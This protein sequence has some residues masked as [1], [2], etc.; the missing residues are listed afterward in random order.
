MPSSQEACATVARGRARPWHARPARI[1]PVTRL[2]SHFVLYVADQARSRDFFVA[3]LQQAPQLDVPGMTEFAL[4][5]GG[6]LGLMPE[7]GIRALLGERLPDPAQARGTPRAELYLVVADPD[8]HHRR[9]LAAGAAELS[10]PALRRWG[11]RA[12]Y[13]LDP[14]GHVLAFAADD[15]SRSGADDDD[16]AESPATPSADGR[17][18]MGGSPSDSGRGQSS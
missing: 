4:A 14:D 8:A 12:A 17:A 13:S 15:A 9:A 11:H 7:Q 18:G 5:G 2:A 10:P 1:A 6:V 3:V 16:T